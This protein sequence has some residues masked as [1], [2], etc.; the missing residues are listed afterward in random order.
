MILDFARTL[1]YT[2]VA[3]EGHEHRVAPP[4]VQTAILV[5][6][7]ARG[8]EAALGGNAAHAEDLAI[9]RVALRAW[10][11]EDLADVLTDPVL[12]RAYRQGLLARLLFEGSPMPRAAVLRLLGTPEGTP[13]EDPIALAEKF[14]AAE[15]LS[16]VASTFGDAFGKVMEVRWPLFLLLLREAPRVQAQR[17]LGMLTLQALPYMKDEA[18]RT[19]VLDRLRVLSGASDAEASMSTEDKIER[20]KKAAAALR[21]LMGVPEGEPEAAP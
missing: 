20:G 12:P 18:E 17:D 14:D 4:S 21:R 9:L 5:I 13:G 8:A 2:P 6:A 1:L 3:H 7:S 19:K 10:L 16:R 15:A 11:P